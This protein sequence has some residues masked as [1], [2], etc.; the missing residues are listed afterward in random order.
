MSRPSGR[1]FGTTR[2]HRRASARKVDGT[3]GC[4]CCGALRRSTPNRAARELGASK[5]AIAHNL[6]DE[7][8][9]VML[10]YVRSDLARLHRPESACQPREGFVPRIRPMREIPEKEIVLYAVDRSG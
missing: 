3:G 9:A 5:L 7:V 10:N 1:P 4:A 8:Q 6:D 2:P